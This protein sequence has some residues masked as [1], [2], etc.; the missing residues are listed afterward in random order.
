[1][2]IKIVGLLFGIA[3]MIVAV[4]GYTVLKVILREFFPEN[5]IVKA[6]TTRM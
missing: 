2:I 4:P 6:L 1:L 3:G 5:K